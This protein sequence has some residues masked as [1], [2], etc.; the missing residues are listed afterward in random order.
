M[1]K[2]IYITFMYLCCKSTHEYSINIYEKTIFLRSHY[3]FC[4]TH[5]ITWIKSIVIDMAACLFCGYGVY[6]H[7]WTIKGRY[8]CTVRR[9]C[10]LTKSWRVVRGKNLISNKSRQEKVSEDYFEL[11]VLE[12]Y[13]DSRNRDG[14]CAMARCSAA[15]RASD[16]Q[17]LGC[18]ESLL[19]ATIIS[20]K[21]TSSRCS[22][23]RVLLSS[24]CAL[25]Q[26]TRTS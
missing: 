16:H 26:L 19:P 6:H 3:C 17:R 15:P 9:T 18:R 12:A 25:E 24:R 4:N 13:R 20:N 8:G 1:T 10:D 5:E 21:S 23:Q 11:K 22:L 14:S 7:Y 2:H